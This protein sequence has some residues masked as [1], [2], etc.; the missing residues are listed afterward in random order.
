MARIV[1]IKETLEKMLNDESRPWTKYL[2]LAE[3]KSGVSRLYLFLG[4]FLGYIFRIFTPLSVFYVISVSLPFRPRK[5]S[6]SFRSDIVF[7]YTYASFRV[8]FPFVPIF[9]VQGSRMTSNLCKG[10]FFAT[11]RYFDYL[12]NYGCFP[13][14]FM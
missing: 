11:P 5:S 6:V 7:L 14:I 10:R 1:A 9:Q 8:C 2:A 13:L 12:E 3:Q 4:I